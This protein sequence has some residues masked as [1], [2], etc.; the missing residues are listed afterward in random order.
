MQHRQC[1][2]DGVANSE[3]QGCQ[4]GKGMTPQTRLVAGS[5]GLNSLAIPCGSQGIAGWQLFAN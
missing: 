1:P 2:V 3:L 5:C 4:G